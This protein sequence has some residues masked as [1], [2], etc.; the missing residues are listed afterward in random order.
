M[1]RRTFPYLSSQVIAD[2]TLHYLSY[3][4][5]HSFIETSMWNF[6]LTKLGQALLSVCQQEDF[7][8]FLS[9]HSNLFH[10]NIFSTSDYTYK[11][12]QKLASDPGVYKMK[13]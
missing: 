9:V 6:S 11:V 4:L 8:H 5:N 1:S 12:L 3:G 2:A 7:K 10:Q 13:T